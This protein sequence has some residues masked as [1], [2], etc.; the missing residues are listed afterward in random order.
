MTKKGRLL[1]A[2]VVLL[3]VV[4]AGAGAELRFDANIAWPMYL[5]VKLDSSTFGTSSQGM[6]ISKFLILFPDVELYWQF[7]GQGLRAGI[8]A[9]VFT[10]ILE[11]VAYPAAFIELD[12]NPFVLS[13]NVGGGAYA[14]FGLFSQA[15]TGAFWLPD[16]NVAFKFNDW[17]RVGVG[18][19]GLFIPS[20]QSSGT[21]L[22]FALYANA[23]FVVPI[24]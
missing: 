16:V 21:I 11:S 1:I 23:R 10:L 8:G 6:D 15:G 14:F 17:F 5:G 3:A 9:R 22:P 18:A 4:A 12:L 24:K 13:A 19:Y 7:G 2:A 20:I